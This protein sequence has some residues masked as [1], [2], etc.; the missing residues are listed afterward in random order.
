MKK[1][2]ILMCALGVAAIAAT[3][4]NTQ[5]KPK[6]TDNKTYAIHTST[7]SNLFTQG[8]IAFPTP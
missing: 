3:A 2:T 1:Q 5:Q 8:N 4:A 6:N 7:P